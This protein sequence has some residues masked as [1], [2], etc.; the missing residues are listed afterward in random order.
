M[1]QKTHNLLLAKG[2]IVVSNLSCHYRLASGK[3]LFAHVDLAKPSLSS[4][5]DLSA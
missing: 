4:L 1:I 3:C 5:Y 2:K